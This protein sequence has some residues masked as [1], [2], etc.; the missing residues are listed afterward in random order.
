MAINLHSKLFQIDWMN[1]SRRAWMCQRVSES[2]TKE[3]APSSLT[4]YEVLIP[5]PVMRKPVSV[6]VIKPYGRPVGVRSVQP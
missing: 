4:K 2:C 6:L 1:I 3:R 5:V